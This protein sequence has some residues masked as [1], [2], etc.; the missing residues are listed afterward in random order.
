VDHASGEGAS[1]HKYGAGSQLKFGS[2]AILYPGMPDSFCAGLLLAVISFDSFLVLINVDY[3]FCLS[4][5][6]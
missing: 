2:Y 6:T 4:F 3:T 1:S 5:D